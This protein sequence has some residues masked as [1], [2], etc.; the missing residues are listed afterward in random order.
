MT[1]TRKQ[2]SQGGPGTPGFEQEL[3]D[4]LFACDP[5]LSRNEWV[6][7][8]IAAKENGLSY[9]DFDQWSALGG[10]YPGSRET[11]TQWTAFGRGDVGAVNYQTIFHFAYQNGWKPTKDGRDL[12]SNSTSG[13]PRA[14]AS[15][16]PS[17]ARE[18]PARDGGRASQDTARDQ[19]RA[20]LKK[21]Q[22]TALLQA[23]KPADKYHPYLVR[24]QISPDG[25]LQIRRNEL[26][27]YLGYEPTAHGETPL[28]GEQ[29]LLCPYHDGQGVGHAKTVELIDENGLKTLVA[30][31]PR[32]KTMWSLEP[33]DPAAPRHFVV[34]G[35]ATAKSV[36]DAIKE[37]QVFAAGAKNNLG[38]VVAE[39]RRRSPGAQIIVLSDFGDD[40]EKTA[41][42]AAEAGAG[43]AIAPPEGSLPEGGSDFN[44]MAAA[45]GLPAVAEWIE[46]HSTH[47]NQITFAGAKHW[48][49][50][51]YV[52]PGLERGSVG[53][54]VGPG[55]VGKTFLALE[56]C[57]SV[58]LGLSLARLQDVFHEKGDGRTCLLLGEDSVDQISNRLHSMRG[59]FPLDDRQ[60]QRL[61]ERMLVLSRLG[62]EMTLVDSSNHSV[63]ETAF[64]EHLRHLC[65]GRRLTVIDPLVR[66]HNG[67]ENDNTA[68]SRLMMVITRIAKET[69]CSIVLL[70]HVGKGDRDD[71]AAARGA[72]AF[73]T[74]A[75]WQLNIRNMNKT[76]A[77]ELKVDPAQM[78]DYVR[79]TGAKMNYGPGIDHF[80]LRRAEGGVLVH[81][82]PGAR[83]DIAAA[84]ADQGRRVSR[85]MPPQRSSPAGR[86]A[87]I[88]S[89]QF[90]DDD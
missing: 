62:Q 15:S 76:E 27:G 46:S 65:W 14:A 11:R 13:R 18:R 60:V 53:M 17:S 34:E 80:W 12:P 32:A 38:N 44:D 70:H 8:G 6:S 33:I 89:P 78:K 55:S 39:I 85:P 75:R 56:L 50:I 61:D 54:I 68:A 19:Q 1:Q 52:L 23:A 72:S 25:L 26:R 77:E 81:T 47:P 21:E 59:H 51:D 79:C 2:N 58:A 88:G 29:I 40:S 3:R 66:L 43:H 41:H 16:R 48:R 20:K 49:K 63:A 37:R 64:V 67:D 83:A 30:G 71:W 86:R 24:K 84:D 69:N 35:V 42:A 45:A 87:N 7:I 73:N 31:V 5:D 74:S 9:E 10:K 4:A 57:A 22:L 90:P 28:A 36:I 82:D